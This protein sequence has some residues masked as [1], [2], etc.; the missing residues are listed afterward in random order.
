MPGRFDRVE[1]MTELAIR[2]DNSTLAATYSPAGDVALIALHGASTGTR[3]H[4]L[5]EHL[6]QVLPPA[7]IGVLTFDRRG[8]GA[9]TGTI[10]RGR[11][12]AQVADALAIADR[13]PVARVGIWG[14][15]QGAW[16]A[17][18]AA[19]ASERVAF[20]T[21]IAA[22]GV[23]PAE[24][25]MYATAQQLARA[26]YGGQVV[27]RALALRRAFED[28]IHG[29][30]TED[31]AELETE[32]HAVR[33]EPWWPHTFLPPR[34]ISPDE[35][36]AWIAEMDFDPRPSLGQVRVPT[37]LFYGEDDAWTPVGQSVDAWR[38]YGPTELDVVVIPGASHELTHPDGTLDPHYAEK[39][40]EWVTTR[41]ARI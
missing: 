5:L 8:E 32:L 36:R 30:T 1:A 13:L 41:A 2:T 24:Q 7:G 19:A 27:E 23:T 28:W 31:A 15:S 38:T 26:G 3:D 39:L 40:V 22:T 37:L 18:L 35:C 12:D 29:R 17:P 16:I 20:L 14:F 25:M 33:T 9:S 6:H 21:L 11:F 4:F 10:S 34:L